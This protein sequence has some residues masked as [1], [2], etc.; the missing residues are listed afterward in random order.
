[1]RVR[2]TTEDDEACALETSF[3]D[4][5]PVR[6][7]FKQTIPWD[8]RTWDASRKKWIVAALYIPD[9]LQFLQECG[10]DIVDDRASAAPV[11]ARVPPMP[12]DLKA[13]FDA[14]FLAYTAPLCVAEGA[15]R[16]LSKYWHPDKGGRPEDFHAVNDAI[17]VI[18]HYL[19]PQP[20]ETFDDDDLP[21]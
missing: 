3:R 12:L 21:F 4:W 1:M 16:A 20:Q 8:G 7:R 11:E 5:D 10:A 15:Y 13:A 14:L 19:D 17:R 6:E 18:R 9:L 2:L